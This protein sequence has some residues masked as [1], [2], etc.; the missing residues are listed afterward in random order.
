MIKKTLLCGVLALTG[1]SSINTYATNHAL[2]VKK[3]VS[4]AG[5]TATIKA[6]YAKSSVVKMHDISVSTSNK[7]VTLQGEVATDSQYE[8]AVA[9]AESIHGVNTVDA[10][11][12]TVKE[13]KAPLADTYITA[14][15]KGRFLKEKL[16][17]SKTIAYWPVKVETKDSV[18]YLTGAVKTAA[19][20]A[21]LVKLAQSIDGVNRV[22]SAI[23][24]R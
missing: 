1:F 8:R 22:D 7:V 23:K 13:S 4:D 9:L 17:G 3:A 18:V 16:F 5:I 19:Q 12:L 24:L 15:V 2:V 21:N 10:K 20:R 11:Q 14:K 6:L